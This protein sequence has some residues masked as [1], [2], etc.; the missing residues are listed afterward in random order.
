MDY[1][2]REEIVEAGCTPTE[3]ARNSV[4]QSWLDYESCSSTG[5][6]VSVLN[7]TV[8]FCVPALE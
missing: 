8:L 3:P 4:D 1:R 7:T 2:G 6:L 5:Q